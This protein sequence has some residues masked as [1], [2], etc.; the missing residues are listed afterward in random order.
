MNIELYN[1]LDEL[2]QDAS[3]SE[4]RF[5]YKKLQ[6][7]KLSEEAQLV[8]DKACKLVKDSMFYRELWDDE[9]PEYQTTKAWDAGYYQLKGIWKQYFPDEFKEFKEL[10][11]KLADKMRPM[12]YELGFLKK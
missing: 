4:D 1:G 8:L 6:S 5:V 2:Y 10:Y 3:T 9:N 11:K 7:L 12:V